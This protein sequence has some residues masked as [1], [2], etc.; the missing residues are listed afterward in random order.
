M[1][2][3]LIYLFGVPTSVAIGTGLFQ[4]IFTSGYGTFTHFFKGNVDFL[5]AASILAGSLA[6]SQVGAILC[7]KIKSYS[8]RYYF[9]FVVFAAIV[10]I[11][12]KFLYNLGY[13]G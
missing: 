5:L 2:P 3:C 7:R 12:L 8:T 6:G 10:V 4:I 9:S 1:T 13:L 11:I